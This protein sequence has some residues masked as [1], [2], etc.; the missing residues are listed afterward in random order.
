MYKEER[1]AQPKTCRQTSKTIVLWEPHRAIKF[2][3]MARENVRR[4]KI[5][6]TKN[7]P[8]DLGNDRTMGITSCNKNS[9]RWPEKMYEEGKHG[10]GS[11]RW[12][13]TLPDNILTACKA[14]VGEVRVYPLEVDPIQIKF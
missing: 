1:A 3:P 2:M 9:C 14:K 11:T 4:G 8:A 13:W 12:K 7:L 10:S 6:A 5:C